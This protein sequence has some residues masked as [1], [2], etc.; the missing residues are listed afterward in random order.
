MDASFM[1]EPN[2]EEMKIDIRNSCFIIWLYER[3]NE[4]FIPISLDYFTTLFLI[5]VYYTLYTRKPI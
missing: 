4:I 2:V 5:E 3:V 1:D